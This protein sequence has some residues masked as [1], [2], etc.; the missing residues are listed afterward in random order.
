MAQKCPKCESTKVEK[1]NYATRI[2][3]TIGV[4]AAGFLGFIGARATVVA[5]AA[6]GAEAGAV[7]GAVAGPAGVAAG[8]A[9]G[10][11]AG[12][13]LGALAGTA[14]GATVGGTAGKAVDSFILNNYKCLSCGH[15]FT[16]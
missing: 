14:A 5:G 1:R 11:F 9:T 2:G 7:V 10:T 8:A 3:A 4:A 15:A 6:A 12:A 13:V 16:E